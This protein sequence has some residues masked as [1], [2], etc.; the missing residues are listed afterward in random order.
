[1]TAAVSKFREL[2]FQ[3]SPRR[4]FILAAVFAFAAFFIGL[5]SRHIG[6][7]D[8]PRV[9]GI[10]AETMI[11]GHWL[12]PRLND[13]S[14]L[15]KPPLYFWADALAMQ[16]FGRNDFAAKLP[17][18][19][20]AFWG[21]LSVFALA[22]GL[23]MSGFGAFMAVIMLATAA[24][25][26]NY[27]RKCMIDI[28]VAVFVAFAM[29]TFRELCRSRKT[30]QISLWF[31]GFVLALGG[32][33]FSK[34]LVGLALPGSALFFYLALDDFYLNKKLNLRRWLYL[35]AGAVLSF[36]PVL[37]W[38]WAL[39][40]QSGADAVYT[41]VWTN[42]FGRFTGSHA[43]HVEPWYYYFPKL[44]EQLQPWTILLP[45]ALWFNIREFFRNRSRTA[46]F[47]LC[48]L[49]ISYLLLMVSAG[50]R[51]VYVLPLYAAE[52]LMIAYMLDYLY[53][54]K[55][56]LPE[57]YDCVDTLTK[58][59]GILLMLGLLGGAAAVVVI[60]VISGAELTAYP[61]PVL[62]LAAGIYALIA[63]ARGNIAGTACALTAGLALTYISIDTVVRPLS[64]YR[65]SYHA[66]FEYC[67][68]Q[69]DAGKKLYLYRPIERESGA[70]L[71][72]L[73]SKL[74]TFCFSGTKPVPGILV[75]VN[76]SLAAPFTQAGFKARKEFKTQGRKY[77]ILEYGRK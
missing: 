28:F 14:F 26:W 4:Y 7:G 20:A 65:K 38:L 57:K 75:L 59:I 11:Y 34:G 6:G 72:Y 1:M 32:A 60:A 12:E 22:R 39:Y 18:A 8:E 33:I 31:T 13:H 74:P 37:L 73:G 64:N 66:L 62:M 42:N 24:Q 69:L 55:L 70:A 47:L 46:L 51:Q 17:S 58:I 52:I 43:E 61:A 21:V 77:W 41:V 35:F 36:I 71:F 54:G 76:Q 2:I 29:W 10:A 40:R 48:W 50:K 53:S 49:I 5:G 45:F 16:V 44:F 9:A 56:K 25:Y 63:M 15:E 27:G 30:G 68:E 3:I 19:F 67:G 23:G